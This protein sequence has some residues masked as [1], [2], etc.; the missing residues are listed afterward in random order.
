MLKLKYC[1]LIAS[2][3]RQLEPTPL[4]EAVEGTQMRAVVLVGHKLP[5]VSIECIRS[6]HKRRYSA[7]TS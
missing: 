2:L 1:N 3:T 4:D 7:R 6:S 5:I